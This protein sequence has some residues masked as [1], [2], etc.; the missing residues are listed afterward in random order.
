[1]ASF[2]FGAG[3]DDY[4]SKIVQPLRLRGVI[5][6]PDKF[7]DVHSFLVINNFPDLGSSEVETLQ[8]QT[9]NFTQTFFLQELQVYFSISD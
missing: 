8:G 3:V 1:M 7:T 2:Q 6:V 4:G 9:Q 5:P